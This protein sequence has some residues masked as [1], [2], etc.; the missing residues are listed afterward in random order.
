M[1]AGGGGGDLCLALASF[2]GSDSGGLLG[3]NQQAMLLPAW[4]FAMLPTAFPVNVFSSG[5]KSERE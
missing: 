2:R 5:S 4:D 1:L 3:I